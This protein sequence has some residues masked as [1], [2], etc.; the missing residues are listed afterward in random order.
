MTTEYVD[1]ERLAKD[2]NIETPLGKK[3]LEIF[4]RNAQLLDKKNKDYGPRNISAFGEFGVLVR[5]NDKVERLKNLMKKDKGG[6]ENESITDTW[7]DLYNY[8][9]IGE[10][11]H[12]GLW[13][14]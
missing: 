1:L 3:S 13:E 7:M 10:M 12:K 14:D 11:C 6:P 8:G 4:L 5:V 9:V 2:L